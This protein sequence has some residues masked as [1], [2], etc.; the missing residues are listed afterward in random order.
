MVSQTSPTLPDFATLDALSTGV[1]ACDSAG[2]I[3][4][5]NPA[6]ETLLGISGALLSGMH[7]EGAF[8]RSPELCEAIRTALTAK[9]IDEVIRRSQGMYR[10]C[11]QKELNR[12]PAL[13][14]DITLHFEILP[15]GRVRGQQKVGGSMS[16]A[17]VVQCVKNA[18]GILHFPEKGGALVNY[19]FVFSQGQ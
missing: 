13:S 19:P 18:I 9:E 1:M 2:T 3:V 16:N 4:Y 15:S 14:G 10:A 6:E 7:Y 11:Y 8:E 5:I 17:S 12:E